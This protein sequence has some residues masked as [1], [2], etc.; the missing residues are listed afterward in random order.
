VSGWVG[1]WVSSN[2]YQMSEWMGE[3]MGEWVSI[4]YKSK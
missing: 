3:W 4:I 1:E 2:F